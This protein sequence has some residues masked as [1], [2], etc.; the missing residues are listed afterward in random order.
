MIDI[1][2]PCKNSY[3]LKDYSVFYTVKMLLAQKNIDF[4][5]YIVDDNSDDRTYEFLSKDF[6]H[7]EN[8]FII[9]SNS[10]GVAGARNTGA[11]QGNSS[12]ILFIDDDTILY[13][14]FT[15]AKTV[16][17]Y[18]D[19]SFACG[20]ERFWTFK[21]WPGYLLREDTWKSW[22]NILKRISFLP[23][24][25]DRDTGHIDLTHISFIGNYG[26]IKRKVFESV[27]G[28]PIIYKGWGMEDT[29]LMYILC[30]SG[31]D[32]GLFSD[33]EI[34]V[35]HLNHTTERNM[36]FLTNFEQFRNYQKTVGITF[37]ETAFFNN[38]QSISPVLRKIN[39]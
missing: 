37:N 24:G 17:N 28:F 29:H 26:L 13:D 39:F 25:V 33:K 4:K 16:E 7:Y 22:S 8:V 9:K 5:I 30:I 31:Y 38:D 32:Y 23:K 10:N 12:L 20:A 14:E 18:K 19:Y 21:D 11:Y 6:S 1:I 2:M 35:Y 3:S 15:L 27:N 34:K 36:T